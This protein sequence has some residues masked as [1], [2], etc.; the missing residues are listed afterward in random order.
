MAFTRV[1]NQGEG[2]E[3]YTVYS[4]IIVCSD[5]SSCDISFFSHSQAIRMDCFF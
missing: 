3:L 5:L 4:S 1:V 2:N